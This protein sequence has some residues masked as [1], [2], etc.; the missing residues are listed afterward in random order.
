[1]KDILETKDIYNKVEKLV[2]ATHLVAGV[3]PKSEPLQSA[4]RQESLKLLSSSLYST[5]IPDSQHIGHFVTVADSCMSLT[6]IALAT[7]LITDMN[8]K[9]LIKGYTVVKDMYQSREMPEMDL[10]VYDIKDT[11]TN[12]IK[13]SAVNIFPA[14]QP[15]SKTFRG[16]GESNVGV[17]LHVPGTDTDR[18]LASLQHKQYTSATSGG[19]ANTLRPAPTPA[20]KKQQLSSDD[21]QS[22]IYALLSDGEAR[23]LPDISKF[24]PSLTD[25]T[26]Q[27][28]LQTLIEMGKVKKIGERRWSR[29]TASL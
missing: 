21:R 17:S 8:A 20:Y 23:L 13:D 5:N 14:H 25:K 7:G 12:Y 26:V 15:S 16:V 1:M 28:D 24:F 29:Y 9:W 6:R 19:P 27:R 2:T 4:L 22:Q 11:P 3:M 18:K 10:A